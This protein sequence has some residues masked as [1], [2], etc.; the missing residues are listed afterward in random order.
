L[1]GSLRLSAEDIARLAST[2]WNSNTEV[3]RNLSRQKVDTLIGFAFLLLAFFS[4]L[5][6]LSLPV[7]LDDYFPAT[8]ETIGA[9]CLSIILFLLGLYLSNVLGSKTY[10]RVETILKQK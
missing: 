8:A 3:A 1:K 2:Y 9:L 10:K 6:G 7:V 4:Q 5:A